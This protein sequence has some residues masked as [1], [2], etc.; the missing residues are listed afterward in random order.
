MWQIYKTVYKIS[1]AIQCNNV[2]YNLQHIPLIGKLFKDS[3]YSVGTAKLTASIIFSAFGFLISLLKQLIYFT[4]L[5]FTPICLVNGIGAAEL[6]ETRT[7][8]AEEFMWIFLC[9][10]IILGARLQH[11]IRSEYSK[12]TDTCLLYM[13]LN[14]KRYFL[15]RA[16]AAYI[17]KIILLLPFF[18]G[19]GL[20][21][22]IKLHVLL[23]AFS[24]M[25]AARIFAD[26]INA[27]PFDRKI[28]ENKKL[29]IAIYVIITP[30]CF[31]AAYI[32]IKLVNLGNAPWLTSRIFSIAG[33]LG[34][35]AAVIVFLLTAFSGLMMIKKLSD[36]DYLRSEEIREGVESKQLVENAGASQAVLKEKDINTETDERIETKKG[37]DYL[38]ALFM[39][40]YKK[41]FSK[42]SAITALAAFAAILGIGLIDLFLDTEL[43]VKLFS[44]VGLWFFAIYMAAFRDRY[45]LALFNNIDK[46][47]LPYAWYRKPDAIVK[48]YFIRLRS[49]FGMNAAMTVP[50]IPSVLISSAMLGIKAK[51]FLPVI[52][53][54]LML[55]LFYS[56]HYLTLYYLIQPYS[57]ET[58]VKSVAY[59]FFNAGVY[60]VSYV[61]LQVDNVELWVLAAVAAIIAVYLA[62]SLVLLRHRAPESFRL[63]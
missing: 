27:C 40:R 36:Y 63:R 56:V 48:S 50:M 14:P 4:L 24:G 57:E 55:T 46:Y 11:H 33:G 10:N 5:F 60:I 54:I 17:K 58:K 38:N 47:M 37:Y 34:S 45:T 62:V 29:N 41:M 30:L 21:L 1:S 15:S 39:A 28:R 31:A 6:I 20:M 22:G 19:F 16:I 7:L 13:R 61:F 9:L 32:P 53:V 44:K 51:I 52:A 12:V 18:I 43:T 2:L 35:P 49:S 3:L 23:T 59:S 42:R 26:G 25:M 8:H